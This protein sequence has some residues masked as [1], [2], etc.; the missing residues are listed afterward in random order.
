MGV[1]C[2]GARNGYIILLMMEK[3]F[4]A[5]KGILRF[6][7]ICG[8]SFFE[9]VDVNH[10][11]YKDIVYTC[12]HNGD[13]APVLKPYHGLYIFLN[14]QHDNY[15]QK[16]F[17]PINGCYKAYARDFDGDGN[18]DIATISLFTDKRQPEEGFVFLKGLGGLNFKPCALPAGI[19]FERA[20][21]MDE[22]DI[23][24]DGKPDLLI[25]ERLF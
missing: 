2:A 5:K 13:A 3:E 8:S 22:G 15:I 6:P 14:H 1:V 20:V 4:S 12:G 23:N 21:T 17:Y 11:G 18:I 10:D 24:G 16:Y 25:R 9:M 19:K 7:P